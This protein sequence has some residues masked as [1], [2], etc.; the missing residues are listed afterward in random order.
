MASLLV[1]G[2]A[3][4]DFV[5]MV[6]SLPAHPEKYTAHDATITGGGCAANA[7]V[8]IARLG[9]KA[10]LSAVLG[11][12]QIGDMIVAGLEAEAVDCSKLS[13][14]AGRRSSFSA[15]TVDAEGERQIVNYRDEQLVGEI[16]L[17]PQESERFDGALADTRRPAAAAE[18]MR[19][20][21]EA[22]VP[23][24]LDAEAPVKAAG[25]ALALASHIGFSAQGLAD[26][27]GTTDIEAGLRRAQTETGAFVCVTDGAAG[28]F[29]LEGGETAHAPAFPVHVVDTL[30]A[31]D[32]WHGAFALRLAEGAPAPA[33]MR[34]ANA[35][36]AIKCSRAGAR[37]AYPTRAD[38]EA[39]LNE[40][41]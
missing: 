29:Y 25:E 10:T 8:A 17:V 40:G 4:V 31:G 7:A 18:V 20:A 32:V 3:V 21:R 2:T 15:V 23:G 37:A 30:G 19:W 27:T 35:V 24:V 12:D 22:G 13:R 6:D 14:I 16:G 36:A 34:F 5:F 41:S 38:A 33:A 1:A 26:L 11:A 39:L 28:S 9:G